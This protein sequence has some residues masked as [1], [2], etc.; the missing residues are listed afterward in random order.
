[1]GT[2]KQLKEYDKVLLE[3]Y[4]HVEPS[5]NFEGIK[6]SLSIFENILNNSQIIDFNN[7]E[8][9]GSNNNNNNNSNNSSKGNVN[10]S[11]GSSKG[12]SNSSSTMN[13]YHR[14]IGIFDPSCVEALDEVLNKIRSA[15]PQELARWR[16]S[17]SSSSNSNS[18]SSS[19]KHRRITGRSRRTSKKYIV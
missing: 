11:S 17:N 16:H 2:L 1:M 19:S 15:T 7:N 13:E 10:S 18:T 6:D 14:F 4:S 9:G 8:E 3:Q 5:W 12:N